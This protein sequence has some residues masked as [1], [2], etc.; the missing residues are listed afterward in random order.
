MK[1]I[2]NHKKTEHFVFREPE[3]SQEL[4]DLFKL[5]YKVYRSSRL[6][7]FIKENKYEIDI[8]QYDF[9]ARHF[10]MYSVESGKETAIGY[11][12][13]VEDLVVTKQTYLNAVL[14]QIP[15]LSQNIDDKPSYDFPLMDYVPETE[16]IK[17]KI[18]QVHRNHERVVEACRMAIDPAVRSLRVAK[19]IFEA[20]MAIYWFHYE[21]HHMF[22]CIDTSKKGFYARYVVC[23]FAGIPESDFTGM[24]VSSSCLFGSKAS[25]SEKFCSRF[26]KMADTYKATG[27]ICCFPSEPNRFAETKPFKLIPTWSR[28]LEQPKISL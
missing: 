2:D 5:R 24:G 19:H 9:H 4:L 11:L 21:F 23:P 12:R 22:A 1:Q 3:N 16:L 20:S 6:A 27:R 8:D 10:G 14:K 13:V 15:Q 28:F 25:L 18:N 17:E 26:E 7:L